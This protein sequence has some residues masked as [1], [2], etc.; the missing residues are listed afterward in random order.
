MKYK[1]I[2]RMSITLHFYNLPE[3]EDFSRFGM[4]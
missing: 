3:P 1:V 2:W 4:I